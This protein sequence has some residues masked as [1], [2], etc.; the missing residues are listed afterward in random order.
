MVKHLKGIRQVLV[1]YP[2]VVE[3]GFSVTGR[4]NPEHKYDANF[5]LVL[6]NSPVCHK[7]YNAKVRKPDQRADIPMDTTSRCAE[8]ASQSDARG[9]QNTPSGRAAPSYRA[10]V[11]ASYD[12]STGKV[13][14]TDEDPEASVI[15]T[16]GAYDSFGKDSWKSLLLQ[17][18]A[19][20]E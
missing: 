3:G 15:Y 16:G 10:P 6:T 12:R 11:V 8:A 13:T 5:G 17:P 1:L 9:S 7:G 20:E 18:V 14:W 19:A 2:Y 4:D